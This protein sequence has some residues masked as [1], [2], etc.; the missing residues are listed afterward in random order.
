MVFLAGYVQLRAGNQRCLALA[1]DL[2]LL[3]RDGGLRMESATTPARH[4]KHWL[5]RWEPEDPAAWEAGGRTIARRN[6]YASIFA[7]QLGFSVWSLWSVL[8][9][10]MVPR[11]GFAVTP[12]QKFLLVSLVTLVGAVV[13]IPY[14]FAVP[15]FGGRNWTIFSALVLLLPTVAAG[16]LMRMPDLPFLGIS[17][18]RGHRGPGVRQLLLLHVEHQLLFP[19]TA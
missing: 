13:R 9:L 10:F 6:L 4:G 16:L 8:V 2:A 5:E 1:A 14:T 7:E 15:R 12:D 3:H 11:T 17:C 19:R 18:R